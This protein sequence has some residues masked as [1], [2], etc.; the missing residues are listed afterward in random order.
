MTKNDPTLWPK[1]NPSL[2][3]IFAIT[4]QIRKDMAT[5]MCTH[6][7]KPTLLAFLTPALIYRRPFLRGPLLALF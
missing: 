7:F 1:K 5:K 6:K 3:T 4:Y 2:Q